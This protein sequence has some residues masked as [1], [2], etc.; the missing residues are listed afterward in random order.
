MYEQYP[1]R[2]LISVIPYPQTMIKYGAHYT[3]KNWRTVSYTFDRTPVSELSR[4]DGRPSTGNYLY[5]FFWRFT[6][7]LFVNF[8]GVSGVNCHD[9][10]L[11][12]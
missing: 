1:G 10:L 6:V 4:Q 12:I 5:I 3:V 7:K 11:R 8:R 9:I 2:K